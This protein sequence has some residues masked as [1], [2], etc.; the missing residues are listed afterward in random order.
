MSE[1]DLHVSDTATQC[2]THDPNQSD[3]DI[4][5]LLSPGYDLNYVTIAEIHTKPASNY[6]CGLSI[7][8]HTSVL[9]ILKGTACDIAAVHDGTPIGTSIPF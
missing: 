2:Q 6:A 7:P 3:D 1:T 9:P 5:L 8:S 4:P